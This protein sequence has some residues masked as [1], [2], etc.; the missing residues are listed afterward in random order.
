MRVHR[1]LPAAPCPHGQPAGILA[2]SER[3]L[4]E[5]RASQLASSPR[6][7]LMK[8]EKLQF[9]PLDLYVSK[10][11]SHVP[12]EVCLAGRGQ[13]PEASPALSQGGMWVPWASALP[14]PEGES[15]SGPLPCRDQWRR[16]GTEQ[17]RLK[18]AAHGFCCSRSPPA[19][20]RFSGDCR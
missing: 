9:T 3:S 18:T 17:D 10:C 2:L 19:L 8:F 13:R 5:R 12:V 11:G 15:H 6:G 20:P 1:P 16:W 7:C 4:L 14:C